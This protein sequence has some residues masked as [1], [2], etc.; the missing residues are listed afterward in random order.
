MG[1]LCREFGVEGEDA[2]EKGWLH[3][4][5]MSFYAKSPTHSADQAKQRSKE[6]LLVI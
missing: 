1:W 3:R 5:V 2:A 6:D 4:N